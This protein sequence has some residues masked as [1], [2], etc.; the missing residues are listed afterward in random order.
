[1]AARGAVRAELTMDTPS[2]ARARVV[3]AFSRHT[4][5]WVDLLPWGAVALVYVVADQYLPLGTQV[6]IMIIFALS[7]DL[8]VGYGGIDTLGHA[9]LFGA[10]AYGAGL[11]ALHVSTEPLS[12]LAVAGAAGALIGLLTGPLVLRT[13]GITQV[14]LTLA[15]STVLLQIVDAWKS[16]T[17]G[18][19]GLAGFRI[20]PIFGLFRFDLAGRTAYWYS[21]AV[22]AAVFL[23]CKALVNSPFGLTIRGIRENPVR[24]RLLGVPVTR[25][26]IMLYTISGLFAGLAGGLTAQV[27]KVVGLDTLAFVLSGNVLVMLILGGTGSLYGAILG[28]T[29]FVVLSDRAAA[30]SPFHWLFALGIA[31]ILAVRFAPSGLAGLLGTLAARLQRRA[32]S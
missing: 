24:M 22:M 19:D 6:M 25:R 26:L 10:G 27:T 7:L 16:V 4:F 12:G 14:M 21:A 2:D 5:S 8:A 9:A 20:A 23:L 17:G 30:I 31:L 11:Y 18:A 28:A 15:V 1:M 32:G 3:R 13:R 29:V